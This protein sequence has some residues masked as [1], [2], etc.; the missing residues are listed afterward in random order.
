MKGVPL[1][2][3][4]VFSVCLLGPTDESPMI[5]RPVFDI[6]LLLIRRSHVFIVAALLCRCCKKKALWCPKTDAQLAK[7]LLHATFYCTRWHACGMHVK[8]PTSAMHE[9]LF[10]TNVVSTYSI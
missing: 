4:N 10:A 1:T 3:A 7:A 2:V 9:A 8:P 6:C 5:Q